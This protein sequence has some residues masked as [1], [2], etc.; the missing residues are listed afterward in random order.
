MAG[1]GGRQV[2]DT[3]RQRPERPPSYDGVRRPRVLVTLA[4]PLINRRNERQ[5]ARKERSTDGTCCHP[6]CSDSIHMGGRD[7]GIMG[8]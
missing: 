5:R 3:V 2:P 1:S 6:L 8:D 4:R 7:L